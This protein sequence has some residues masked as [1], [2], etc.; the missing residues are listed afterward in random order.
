MAHSNGSSGPFELPAEDV[1]SEAPPVYSETA[2]PGQIVDSNTHIGDDGRINVDLDSKLGRTLSRVFRAPPASLANLRP[3]TPPPIYTEREQRQRSYPVHLNIVI[4]V[5]GSRGDVQPFVAL[6]TELQRH[7]HRVRLATHDTFASFVRDAGLEFYAIGGDPAELMA[8]MVKNPGLIPNMRSL[9]AGDVQRKRE[10]VR[11]MLDGCW[12]SCVE[13]DELT[14]DPFVADAIIANPPSFAHVHCAQA[15]GIP[16][17]LMFTMPWSSTRAFP[18]PLANLKYKDTEPSVANYISYGIVEWMTWQGLG[19]VINDWRNQMDLEP[20]PMSEGPCLAE[21][22]KVPFTYCWSPALVPKPLDWPAHIDVCG[23]FF[24]DPPKYEPPKD[25]AAFLDA[26]DPPV[27]IG[28][29]SI[30]IDDPERMTSVILSAVKATGVRAIVSRGWSNLGEAE[31]TEQ[32]FYLGDCPHEWLF[33]HVSSVVHHGGAGTTACGLRNGKPTTIV[34]F[35]GDQPFWGNMIA[36]SGAGP[37]P[38]PQKKL[39]SDNLAEAIRYCQSPPAAQAAF[40]ISEKMKMEEGVQAAVASFHK[41]LPLE[42]MSCDIFPDQPAVWKYSKGKQSVKLSKLAVES[43]TA[44]L[45]IKMKDFKYYETNTIII[46]NRRWDPVTGL[47]SAYIGTATD[48]VKNTAG[49]FIDPY[50]EYRKG[51]VTA[52]HSHSASRSQSTQPSQASSP[53]N[54]TFSRDDHDLKHSKTATP[55]SPSSSH[56]ATDPTHRPSTALVRPPS[57]TPSV[58]LTTTSERER[59]AHNLRTAGKMA[60]A[61]A[62]SLGAVHSSFFRGMIVDLP[63]AVAEGMRNAPALYGENVAQHQPV[64]DW[65][66]GAVVAGKNF[67]WGLAEGV[68]GI[69]TQPV[70][71]A[72]EE[73]ALG[74]VKGVGRGL[75]GL[76]LKTG[77]A[78]VG[79]AGY[80]GQGVVKSL[81][82]LGHTKTRKMVVERRKGEGV[83]IVARRSVDL[84][85]VVAEFERLKNG[86]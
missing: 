49:I 76:G 4:Q 63:L 85:R 23:F 40:E 61:S 36:A 82:A 28:F 57:P 8:Y 66:S 58:A 78:V 5:V 37:V 14:R 6:G 31:S 83:W 7:G 15:L 70:K 25:L 11:E 47:T 42:N 45:S 84:N 41:N 67:A 79:V 44:K 34:P 59:R 52:N 35:F 72:R 73:G 21:T 46:E 20:V 86:R 56:S 53:T 77:S 26:G 39:T 1:P 51:R 43:V 19:D 18:H 12:R 81:R 69:V 55:F 75:M 71:G 27:Y 3:S 17:H 65:K 32:V 74:A 50:Q 48:V 64:T 13:P 22:L 9:R 80:G 54:S 2:A 60:T 68:S 38:I 62:K 10:M 29:G 24:R 33:Q 16:V 30:V